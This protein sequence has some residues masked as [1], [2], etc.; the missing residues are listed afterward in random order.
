MDEFKTLALELAK[1]VSNAAP[2]LWEIARRQ[3]LVRFWQ[4]VFGVVLSVAVFGLAWWISRL[5]KKDKAT[6]DA[7]QHDWHTNDFEGYWYITGII[8]VVVA[9]LCVLIPCFLSALGYV[10]NPEYY[11]IKILLELVK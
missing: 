1:W 2:Q 6:H 11:A 3:T 5:W 4:N 7:A 8:M 9:G 10:I